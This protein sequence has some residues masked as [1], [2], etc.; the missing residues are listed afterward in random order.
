MSRQV[1]WLLGAIAERFSIFR[2]VF[3]SAEDPHYVVLSQR[4]ARPRS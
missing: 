1:V 4:A 2:A 3:Q